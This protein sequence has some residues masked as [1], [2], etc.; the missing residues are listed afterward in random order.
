MSDYQLIG[1]YVIVRSPEAGVFVGILRAI[2]SDRMVILTS[3]KDGEELCRGMR[4]IHRWQD[5][6]TLNE[7]SLLGVEKGRVSEPVEFG[8]VGPVCEILLP[9]TKAKRTF[10]KGV[11]NI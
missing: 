9:T 6:R 7:V 2:G 10:E 5:R 1:K 8:L 4:N 11:W 3:S